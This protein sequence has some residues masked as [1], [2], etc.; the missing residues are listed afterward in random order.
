MGQGSEVLV[1]GRMY[2]HLQEQ[3]LN[4]KTR[5]EEPCLVLYEPTSI[6]ETVCRIICLHKGMHVR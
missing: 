4:E 3:D 5:H 6:Q 2:T 1:F